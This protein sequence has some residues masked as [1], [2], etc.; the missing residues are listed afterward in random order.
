MQNK[1]KTRGLTPFKK[2][3]SGNPLGAQLHNPDLKTLRALTPQE[4]ADIA[5]LIL[6]QNVDAMREIIQ[7]KNSS[8]LKVWIASCAVKAI[9]K[10]DITVLDVL[11]NRMI[12]KV[13]QKTELTGQDGQPLTFVAIVEAMQK[14]QEKLVEPT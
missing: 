7:D 9:A 8:T 12:G 4:F 1:S 6:R 2:G 13:P 5:G 14:R 3:Q 10:G 11:L